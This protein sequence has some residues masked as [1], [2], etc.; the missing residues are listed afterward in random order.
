MGAYEAYLSRIKG[1]PAK[2]DGERMYARIETK[3]AGRAR[4]V[5][6]MLEGALA[7]LLIGFGFYFSICP[8]LSGEGVALAEYVLQQENASGDLIMNYVFSD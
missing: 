2:L 8:Y 6:L 5:R 3:I 1:L 7:V 4:R